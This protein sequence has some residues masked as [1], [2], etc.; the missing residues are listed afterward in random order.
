MIT[1]HPGIDSITFTVYFQLTG[2]EGTYS[3][4]ISLEEM[5]KLVVSGVLPQ[6]I[7]DGMTER[8][9]EEVKVEEGLEEPVEA[10]EEE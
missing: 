8:E 3:V 6:T 2:T 5:N 10:E 9:T 4:D 7:R 1:K